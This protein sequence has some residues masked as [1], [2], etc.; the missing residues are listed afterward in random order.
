MKPELPRG[1]VYAVRPHKAFASVSTVKREELFGILRLNFNRKSG[2]H[3][4]TFCFRHGFLQ[5][6]EWI[7]QHPPKATTEVR[8]VS[9]V[10]MKAER[11]TSRGVSRSWGYGVLFG[12]RL[13]HLGQLEPNQPGPSTPLDLTPVVFGSLLSSRH[14]ESVQVY[15]V[16]FVSQIWNQSFL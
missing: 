9:S 15:L 2:A 12:F 3:A 13:L 10:L 7:P 1:Y 4:Y 5:N 6:N 14:D 11:G 8:S 16:P